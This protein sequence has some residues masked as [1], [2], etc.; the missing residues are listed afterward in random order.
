MDLQTL[1]PWIAALRSGKYS[2]TQSTLHDEKG[3]C[4]LGV[5][6]DVFEVAD[7]EDMYKPGGETEG[8]DWVYKKLKKQIPKKIYEKGISMNDRGRSFSEIADMI[9]KELAQ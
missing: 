2:Q 3:F 1:A 5:A 7:L 9:E 8:P 6:A 4:C